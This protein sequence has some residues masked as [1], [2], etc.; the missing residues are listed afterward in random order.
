MID[1][2]INAWWAGRIVCHQDNPSKLQLRPGL[3][4]IMYP[5]IAA[6]THA[7]AKIARAKKAARRR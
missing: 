3:L 7:L 2:P 4:L 6:Y 1:R 5:P